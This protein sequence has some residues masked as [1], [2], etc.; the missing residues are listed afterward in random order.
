MTTSSDS[1]GLQLAE[2]EVLEDRADRVGP[3]DGFL[4]LRRLVVRNHYRNGTTSD[5]YTCDIVSRAA[6]DAVTVVLYQR[7]APSVLVGLRENLRVPVW[8]RRCS[9]NVLW[10]DD[11]AIETLLETVAGVLEPGDGATLA[12]ALGARA[13]AEIREEVGLAVEPTAVVPLGRA[14]FPSPGITDE[15][16]YFCAAEVDFALA[17]EA[18]GDGSTMEELGGLRVLPLEDALV[19]C[20]D[21]R[22][23]DMK[24]E[25]GLTRLRDRLDTV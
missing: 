18:H 5:E 23:P 2:V 12:A 6:V 11:P 15:K 14:S 13:A 7:T 17:Q 20:R 19:R 22:I 1:S 16:V 24:T 3:R 4:Q 25:I 9:E 21:G 10:P 8:L